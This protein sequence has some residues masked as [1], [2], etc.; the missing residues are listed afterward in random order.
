MQKMDKIFL[1]DV[2]VQAIIGVNSGERKK[3]QNL[4][5]NVVLFTS[6]ELCGR[7]D[8]IDHTI[9]YATVCKAVVNYTETS[10]HF[11]LEALS[12]GIARICCLDFGVEKVIVTVDKVHNWS[13][14][15]TQWIP[16]VAVSFI[17]PHANSS[18]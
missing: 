16:I 2:L 1:R 18:H 3:K 7:T 13:Q 14:N 11:T 6:V 10:Q 8:S 4:V 9:N 12:T 15:N 5:V 17:Q